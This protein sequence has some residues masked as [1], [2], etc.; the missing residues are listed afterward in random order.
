MI[1]SVLGRG[2]CVVDSRGAAAIKLEGTGPAKLPMIVSPSADERQPNN[3]DPKIEIGG[4]RAA[5]SIDATQSFETQH[6]ER[7]MANTSVPA[8]W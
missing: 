1:P 2:I 6:A 4:R 3:W 7:E 5:L 8:A